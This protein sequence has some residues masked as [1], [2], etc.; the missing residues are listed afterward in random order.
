MASERQQL[1][2]Q[3]QPM[4]PRG[5][6]FHWDEETF[7]PNELYGDLF[8][9]GLKESTEDNDNFLPDH[10]DMG[11][12]LNKAKDSKGKLTDRPY[13]EREDYTDDVYGSLLDA[14]FQF[15]RECGQIITGRVMH[16][17]KDKHGNPIGK[18]GDLGH[19]TRVYSVQFSNGSE[20]QLD[21]NTI[22]QNIFAGGDSEG[23]K[24]L[25][26]AD[27]QAYQKTDEALEKKDGFWVSHNGNKHRVKTIKGW[28]LL[29]K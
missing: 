3:N 22:A 1:C 7:E 15:K 8:T 29:V 5:N 24:A 12:N 25:W 26:L 28:W 23:H 18:V 27:I 9:G 20:K 4:I 6:L 14:E 2:W 13:I 10:Q 17:V 19:N 16:R 21:H 11:T